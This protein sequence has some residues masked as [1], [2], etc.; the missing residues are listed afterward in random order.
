MPRYKPKK[1]GDH[2]HLVIPKHLS[3]EALD[4][5]NSTSSINTLIWDIVEGYVSGDLID[6]K[7]VQRATK[8]LNKFNSLGGLGMMPL[9][10]EAIPRNNIPKDDTPKRNI[11]TSVNEKVRPSIEDEVIIDSEE[12]GYK[13]EEIIYNTSINS[14][15][16]ELKKDEINNKNKSLQDQPIREHEELKKS[17]E[18]SLGFDLEKIRKNTG[19]RASRRRGINL[20]QENK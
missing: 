15:D 2:M 4:F 5:I 20:A 6:I 12:H 16:K 8:L 17:K 1:Y 14:S 3:Q 19:I 18:E 10:L 7:E 11:D 13:K 9:E